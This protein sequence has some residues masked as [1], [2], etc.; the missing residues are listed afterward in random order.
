VVKGVAVVTCDNRRF[1]LRSDE[2]TY[3]AL[4][5]VHRLENQGNEVLELIEIQIGDYLE[6]DDI[7]RIEDKY[8]R[9]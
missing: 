2:S 9:A 5:A 3:I 6:E 1:G 4:G 7:V 8:G